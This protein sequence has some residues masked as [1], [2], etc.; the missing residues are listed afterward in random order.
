MRLS[1]GRRYWQDYDALPDAACNVPPP[2]EAWQIRRNKIY[3]SCGKNFPHELTEER[4]EILN[5][6]AKD[7]Y[8]VMLNGYPD[9]M[10][11]DQMAQLLGISEKRGYKLL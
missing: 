8:T 1:G 9:V 5:F 10:D 3:G 7:A 6:S 4:R 11:I 2:G